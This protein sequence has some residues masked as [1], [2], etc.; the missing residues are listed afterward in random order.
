MI[1][2]VILRYNID[3]GKIII[4]G[5]SVAG[6]GSVR[7]AEYCYSGK[8]AYGIKPCGVFGVDPPLD[9]ER[10]YNESKNAVNRNFSKDAVDESK[11]LI[12]ILTKSLK[13]TPKTN[14]QSYQK[15]SPILL[16]S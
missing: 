9:Y 4:G 15:N 12:T 3:P 10:L 1:G 2:E 13:G 11:M 8:S 16:F 7:H 6:T 14:L 5:M